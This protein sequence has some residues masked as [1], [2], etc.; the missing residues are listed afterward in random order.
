MLK[1]KCFTAAVA[2]AL[3]ACSA[4]AEP[5]AFMAPIVGTLTTPPSQVADQNVLALNSAM[6]DLYSTAGRVFQLNILAQHPLIL[7]LFSGAGGA[8]SSTARAN[9]R[10]RRRRFRSS[11]N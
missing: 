9:S 6:F 7:G 2:L 11:I 8:S 1:I 4:G 10:S 5:P 3:A